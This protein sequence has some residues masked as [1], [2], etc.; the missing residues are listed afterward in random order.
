MRSGPLGGQLAVVAAS[1]DR[2]DALQ[3]DAVGEPLGTANRWMAPTTDGTRLLA[4]RTPH[5]GGVLPEYRVDGDRLSRT[6]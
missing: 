1:R 6:P 5:I 3:L 2:R 4:V